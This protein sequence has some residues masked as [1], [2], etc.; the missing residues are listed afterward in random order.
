MIVDFPLERDL[1]IFFEEGDLEALRQGSVEGLV[2]DSE[3]PGVLSGEALVRYEEGFHGSRPGVARY[4]GEEA[5]DDVE[6]VFGEGVLDSLEDGSVYSD[7]VSEYEEVPSDAAVKF[8]PPGE[9]DNFDSTY[10]ALAG[11]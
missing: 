6:V 3:S 9:Y 7:G 5:V 11:D 10:Q 8:F 2:Y 1:Y 4:P